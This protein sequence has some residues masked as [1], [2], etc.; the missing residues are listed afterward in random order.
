MESDSAQHFYEGEGT[1]VLVDI[2]KSRIVVNHGEIS[3]FM[4][5]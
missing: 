4:A 3:G 1:V 5:A 2:R